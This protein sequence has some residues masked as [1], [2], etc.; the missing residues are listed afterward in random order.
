MANDAMSFGRVTD[1]AAAQLFDQ[2]SSHQQAGELPAAIAVMARLVKAYPAMAALHIKHGT[3]LWSNGDFERA[4]ASFDQAIS[5]EP[6][7]AEAYF[8]KASAQQSLQADQDAL[9]NYD[10]ALA[11]RP[12]YVEALNN[13]AV[14]LKEAG[15]VRAAIAAYRAAIDAEPSCVQAWTGKALCELLTGDFEAGWRSYEWRKRRFGPVGS[16]SQAPAWQGEDLAGKTL[17]I[18]AEQGLGD[19]VQF[20]RYAKQAKAL[21]AK[22]ILQ[23]QDRLAKLIATLDPEIAV[24]RSSGA[25]PVCDYQVMLLSMPGIL[26]SDHGVR[27]GAYLSADRDLIARWKERIGAKGFRVGIH[28]QGEKKWDGIDKRS[29]KE[30]SFPL[31]LFRGISQISGIRLISLQKNDGLEQL[32]A[33]PAGMQVESPG[34]D[35]DEG[36]D[37]FADSA[38]IMAN[39]DLVISSDS[40]IAHLGGA[41]GCPVWLALQYVPDWR[42]QLGRPDSL[43]YRHMRLFRQPSRGNWPAVFTAMET[44]LRAGARV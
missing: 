27:D 12:A 29:D 7:N 24:I 37:G 10:R 42:W 15:D 30:R 23:V 36:P 25:L 35:F 38:A 17:L 18:Q 34:F 5:L 40:A 6:A 28:W 16:P 11:I 20:C 3:I 26:G 9:A 21:G 22:V 41:I 39:L 8:C 31:E 2:A 32:Q 43:W 44:E 4:I 33:L 14:L 13:K 19:T 1:A